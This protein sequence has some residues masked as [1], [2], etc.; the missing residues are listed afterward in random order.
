MLSN[1]IMKF[2]RHFKGINYE[3]VENYFQFS[4]IDK[5]YCEYC[6]KE[7]KVNTN[8]PFYDAPSVDHKIPLSQGGGNSFENVVICCHRCNI[9]KGTMDAE[10]YEDLLYCIRKIR[11]DEQVEK[12]LN[13]M[14]RGRLANKLKREQRK[15]MISEFV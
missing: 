15:V 2:H 1:L 14:F 5:I 13:Q 9:V 3:Q 11:T 4:R 7:L 12:M 10:T 8:Y 6:G